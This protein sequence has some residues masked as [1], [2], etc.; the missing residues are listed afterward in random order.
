MAIIAADIGNSRIKLGLFSTPSAAGAAKLPQPEREISLPA[1]QWDNAVLEAWLSDVPKT[2]PWWIASV[3]RPAAARLNDRIGKHWHIR[4]LQDTDL[5]IT[6]AV[7]R[8][9]HVGIDR[10]AGAVA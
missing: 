2:T 4:N 6:A 5:P 7:E 1:L 10:L 8:P 3:N 9:D